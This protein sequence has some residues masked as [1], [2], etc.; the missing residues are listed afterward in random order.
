M[1]TKL[2]HVFFRPGTFLRIA[3]RRRLEVD[4]SFVVPKSRRPPIETCT[5]LHG[6]QVLIVVNIT[7]NGATVLA[8]DRLHKCF[9][10]DLYRECESIVE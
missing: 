7:G 8:G 3:D 5:Y 2:P 10:V 1:K 6:E 9:E 4:H